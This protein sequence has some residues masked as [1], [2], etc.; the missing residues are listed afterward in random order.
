MD[1]SNLSRIIAIVEDIATGHYSNEIMRFTVPGNDEKTVRLAEAI[2]LMMVKIETREFTLK[3]YINQL[4]A[5][6]EK[7]HKNAL[8]T[9]TAISAA[10]GARN[11][12]TLGHSERVSALGTIIAKRM[13]LTTDEVESVRIAGLLHDVGKIGFSDDIF[14]NEEPTLPTALFEKVKKHPQIAYNILKSLDVLLNAPEY[15]LKHHER[16]DGKGYPAGLTEKDIP[17]GAQI[18]SVCDIY[19]AITTD[20]SY[21]KGKS[22]D[23]AFEI[24]RSLSGKA[25]NGK[26]VVALI[27]V[28]GIE[29]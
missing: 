13:G 22:T 1:D 10:L 28:L 17:I 16:L 9:V 4:H 15:I 12:Y 26:I 24:L 2:G 20:R 14:T 8:D 18:I 11:E 3:E 23:E 5:L 19:D 6:N 21:Q 7:L 29:D 25:V 27:H